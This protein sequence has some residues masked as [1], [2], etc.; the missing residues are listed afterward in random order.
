MLQYQC[1]KAFRGILESGNIKG[2]TR[3][4]C[5][6]YEKLYPRWSTSQEDDPLVSCMQ[7]KCN[8]CPTPSRGSTSR[9]WASRTSLC[10]SSERSGMWTPLCCLLFSHALCIVGRSE[11]EKS[12]GAAVLRDQGAAAFSGKNNT[13]CHSKAGRFSK[14]SLITNCRQSFIYKP[15]SFYWKSEELISCLPIRGHHCEQ[16]SREEGCCFFFLVWFSC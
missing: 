12:S 13:L 1:G 15:Q 14:A 8:M 2:N 10:M 11:V 6:I 9:N 7:T 4:Q 3:S 5:H 16:G